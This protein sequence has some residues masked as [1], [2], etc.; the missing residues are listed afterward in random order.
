MPADLLLRLCSDGRAFA[1]ESISPEARR[2][3]ARPLSAVVQLSGALASGAGARGSRAAKTVPVVVEE[4]RRSVV[5]I[6]T[7]IGTGSGFVIDDEGTVVTNRHV[8]EDASTCTVT[9]D[10]RAISPGIVIFRSPEADFAVVKVALPTPDYMC[11]S[12]RRGDSIAVGE[13]VVAL[14]FPQDAG[15]NV[16]LGIVS[17]VQV[18]VSPRDNVE[19]S[20]HEWVRTSAEI[21][22]GNSGGPL[23]DLHGNVVG[24]ACWAIVFDGNGV[25]VAGMNYCI[26]HT[27]LCRE[28]R[29]FRAAVA[30]GTI[31]VPT[32]EEILRGSHQPDEWD[33]LDLA[34]SLMCSRFRMRVVKKVPFRNSNRAFQHASIVSAMGDQLDIHVD[35][36]VFKDG[37]LYLTM[38]CAVGEVSSDLRR[39]AKAMETILAHNLRLPHWNF[40]LK[41]DRLVLRYS[42]ELRLLDAVEIL[43]AVQ[44]MTLVLDA[45]TSDEDSGDE[46][47]GDENPGE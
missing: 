44:D 1:D 16:T 47:S 45:I 6:R 8:V 2:A 30:D 5:Q 40:A 35:S 12:E 23:V 38:Y 34:L 10:S 4:L 42:R 33:E 9:F 3:A 19:N 17:A 29:R 39:D 28:A 27:V 31:R 24:M 37:P 22:G 25:P 14:G 36:F 20:R 11:L 46:N 7:P 26:P 21:N 43:S 13:Q 41:D 18:R 32:A 15:F